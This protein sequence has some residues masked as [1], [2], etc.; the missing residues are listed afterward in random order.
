[1]TAPNSNGTTRRSFYSLLINLLGAVIT[2]IVAL[3]AA[4]YLLLKPKGSSGDQMI[5]IADVNSLEPGRPKEVVYFR[6][7]VDGW[8]TTKEKT[9]AWVVK[10]EAGEVVAFDPACTHLACAYHWE[11]GQKSFLCPCHT[12]I[13]GVDGKV[14]SGPAPRAL[15]RYVTKIE[16][17][18]LLIGT[19]LQKA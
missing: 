2:G 19:D 4:A 16:G 5:E 7:R 11:E 3:P 14:V 12:S 8:K 18:K 15:D 1:M 17:G 10:S 9:T 6:T 13:F